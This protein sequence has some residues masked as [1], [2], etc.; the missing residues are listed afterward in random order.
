M[1]DTCKRLGA[2]F[3]ERTLDCVYTVNFYAG[4]KNTL[5]ASKKA[6]AGST[7][8]CDQNWFGVDITTFKE[9]AMRLTREQKSATSALMG[10][11]IGMATGAITSGAIDRAIDRHKAEKAAKDAESEHEELYG[12]DADDETNNDTT[13]EDKEANGKSAPGAN[14]QADNVGQPQG[15]TPAGNTDNAQAQGGPQPQ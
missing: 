15:N 3:D 4:E 5:Y 6:Y 9:N 7:F 10:S 1:R 13:N 11:G 2:M 14:N 12:D 8:N